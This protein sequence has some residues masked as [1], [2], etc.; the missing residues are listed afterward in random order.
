VVITAAFPAIRAGLRS[1]V[2]NDPRIAV[3][4]ECASPAEWDSH[5]QRLN[6]GAIA[7]L[8]PTR[9]LSAQWIDAVRQNG[10]G[11]AILL[12]FSSPPA[13]LPDLGVKTW[14]LL[15]LTA[16]SEEIISALAALSQGLWVAFPEFI[17]PWFK[18]SGAPHKNADLQPVETL[19]RREMQTLQHLAEGFANKEIALRMGISVQTVKYHI[20]SIYS[21]LGVNNRTEA[22]RV[23]ILQGLIHL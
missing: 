11:L 13:N 12:L 15:P 19:T 8:A 23:G 1:L 10:S 6:Q 17:Q 14:G 7:I 2:E 3:V 20:A 4:A 5:I 21:K 22:V 16:S 9:E 18:K